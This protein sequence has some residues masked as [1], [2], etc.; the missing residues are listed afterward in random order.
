MRDLAKELEA[1]VPPTWRPQIGEVLVGHVEGYE[2]V[3]S[4]FGSYQTCIIHD[5]TT[6]EKVSVWLWHLVLRDLFDREHPAIGERVGLMYL[7]KHESKDYHRYRL[8]VDRQP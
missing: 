3:R 5:E 2:T 7:G 6:G 4:K 1:G 8:M